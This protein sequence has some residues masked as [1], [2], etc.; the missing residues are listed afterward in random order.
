MT[1][2]FD[3][4][5]FLDAQQ[6]VIASAMDELRAGR[7]RSHWMWFV[8]PQIAGLGHSAMAQR[9]AIASSDEARAY[10]AHPVLGTRLHACTALVLAV[11]G[12]S[13]HAIFGSPDDLKFR[14]SMTLFSAVQDAD[15]VYAGA[16]QR[17]HGGEADPQTLA[18]L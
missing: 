15:P 4:Q 3:L 18:R 9:Y 14:S 16:L 11:P 5:R 1:S 17:F 2:S 7:K 10:L 8:F 12:R 13:A 6:P